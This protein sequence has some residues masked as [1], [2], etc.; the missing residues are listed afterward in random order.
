M[1]RDPAVAL[2]PADP[3]HVLG[4]LVSGAHPRA[5]SPAAAPVPFRAARLA[6]RRACRQVATSLPLHQSAVA[7]AIGVSEERLIAAHGGRFEP[8]ESPMQSRRLLAQW[9]QIAA[10]IAQLGEVLCVVGDGGAALSL[11]LPPEDGG[12]LDVRREQW[13]R[14]FAVEE[15]LSDGSL[16]RSLQFFGA[17]GQAI[18]RY[19]LTPTSR[20][21]VYLDLV[22]TFCA[23]ELASG[24]PNHVH[25]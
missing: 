12:V 25:G 8:C 23:Y 22:E 4:E 20:A 13:A 6:Y 5:G 9:P 18:V 21:W 16:A 3:G 10:F 17:Q 24:S 7:R 1:Q 11:L 14:G 15:R 19:V 2:F